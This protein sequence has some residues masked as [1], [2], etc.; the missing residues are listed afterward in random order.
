MPASA[1]AAC[2]V[3]AVVR[4]PRTTAVRRA[5][6]TLLFLLGLLALALVFGGSAQAADLGEG[7]DPSASGGLLTS[8][9]PERGDAARRSA[10]LADPDPEFT[11]RKGTVRGLVGR[12]A[13]VV[14]R[15]AGV[16][17]PVDDAVNGVVGS[18]GLRDLPG[19]LGLGGSGEGPGGGT[20]GHGGA[21]TDPSAAD[22]TSEGCPVHFRGHRTG[23]DAAWP[24]PRAA[25]NRSAPAGAADPAAD[26]RTEP[27]AGTGADDGGHGAPVAPVPGQQSPAFLA[28]APSAYAGDDQG[29]RGGPHEH[30]A[31]VPDGA[32]AVPLCPGAPSAADRSPTR[33]RSGEIPRFPG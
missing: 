15:T 29:Q 2:A 3:P 10:R 30:T 18:S 17:R 23:A 21:G 1:A 9:S 20:G 4:R 11:P 26:R 14:G 33:E 31:V 22:G 27:E 16:A 32:Q 25:A 12:L 24:W 28:P 19:R 6:L 8:E 5:L 13:A 7:K